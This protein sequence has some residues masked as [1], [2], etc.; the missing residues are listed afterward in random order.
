M[1]LLEVLNPPPHPLREFFKGK[2]ITLHQICMV[3]QQQG[4]NMCGTHASLYLRGQVGLKADVESV[5]YALAKELGHDQS[6]TVATPDG[7]NTKGQQSEEKPKKRGTAQR[8]GEMTFPRIS[9]SSTGRNDKRP[10]IR[11]RITA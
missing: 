10:S 5:L 9:P 1:P 11:K 2:G 3:M 7:R 6:S 8:K 4:V